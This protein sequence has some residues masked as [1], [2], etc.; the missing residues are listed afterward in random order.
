MKYIYLAGPILGCTKSEASD[1]RNGV[2]QEI[3]YRLGGGMM[4]M[5]SPITCI[6][7]LRCEPIIGERYEA[8]YNDPKFGTARAIG[9]KNHFDTK[10]AD[11]VLAFLPKPPEDRHQSYGTIVEIGWAKA[12][13]KPVIVVSDDSS[14]AEHPVIQYCADWFLPDLVSAVDVIVGLLAGYEGGKNL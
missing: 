3:N 14:I 10:Q 12:L 11:M 1:W 8:G 9:A 2:Q 5:K 7:P 4:P 6:S 13:E